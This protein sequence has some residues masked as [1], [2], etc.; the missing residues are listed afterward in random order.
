MKILFV[1]C[2]DIGIRVTRAIPDSELRLSCQIQAMRRNPSA[3]PV[4]IDSIKGDLCNSSDLLAVLDRSN[5][6]VIIVTLTADSMSDQGYLDSYVAGAKALKMAAT[7]TKNPPSLVIWISSSGVYGQTD[8]EWV[9]ELS[10]VAPRSFRGKRLVQAEQLVSSLSTSR[11]VDPNSSIKS[12]VIRFS[13]IYGPGRNRLVNQI[14]QGNI[15]PIEPVAWTNRI[16]SEDCAG[17][18]VHLLEQY[19][20]GK[21]LGGLYLAT[22]DEPSSAHET[23]SWLAEE[24]ELYFSVKGKGKNNKQAGILSNR[25]CSNKLL[26]KSG[27]KFLFPTFREGYSSLLKE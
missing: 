11:T 6:D 24:L 14:R 20:Q 26:K 15:A 17:V 8:G 5:I 2:G 22:D 23:Q 7:S 16:H 9:D 4:G 13:G 3:L 10:E 19:S 25:R 18:I 12:T 21:S 1:G 27:Y